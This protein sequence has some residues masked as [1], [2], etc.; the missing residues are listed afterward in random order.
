MAAPASDTAQA[1]LVIVES[2]QRFKATIT[3]EHKAQ[4]E[5]TAVKDVVDAILVIQQNLVNRRANR[6]LRKLYP[7]V[8]G[9]GQYSSALDVLSNGLSPYLPFIWVSGNLNEDFC[10]SVS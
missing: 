3:P 1:T 8:Q 10:I 2:V 9:L 6:N 4:I 7:F 5:C